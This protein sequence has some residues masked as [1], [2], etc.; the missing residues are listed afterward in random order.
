MSKEIMRTHIVIEKDLVDSVDRL[1]GRRGR[2]QFFAQAVADKLARAHLVAVAKKAVGSL[3][4][5]DIPGWET[6][7]SA[8][9]WVHASRQAD[10]ERL[11]AL[12]ER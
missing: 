6:S 12:H 8:V 1:V 7:E 5:A 11:R 9:E 4:D 2:S 10:E 3:A